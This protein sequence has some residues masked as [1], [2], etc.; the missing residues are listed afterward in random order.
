[1]RKHSCHFNLTLKEIVEV[2]KFENVGL[3]LTQPQKLTHGVRVAPAY[4]YSIFALS[5]AYVGLGF[6]PIHPL[7]LSTLGLVDGPLMDLG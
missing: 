3:G 6:F 5:L 1:M 4:I 2:T 7:T